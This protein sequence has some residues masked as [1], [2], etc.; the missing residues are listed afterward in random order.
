MSN[1]QERCSDEDSAN[2]HLTSLS[3]PCSKKVKKDQDDTG[4]IIPGTF[5]EPR[6]M[7]QK[8]QV[9][10]ASSFNANT[11]VDGGNSLAQIS[12]NSSLSS[13]YAKSE[14]MTGGGNL[15]TGNGG[16]LN[17]NDDS[18]NDIRSLTTND[19]FEKIGLSRKV[20]N[21][22]KKKKGINY[23]YDWQKEF[24]TKPKL[25]EGEN[26]ILSL[27]TGAGKSLIADLLMLRE[28]L[29]NNKNCIIILPYVAGTQ[30]KTLSLSAFEDLGISVKIYTRFEGKI[31]PAKKRKGQSIYVATIERA[32]TLINS[33]IKENRLQEIGLIV[34]DG[35]HMIGEKGRGASIEKLL[36]KYLMFGSGQIIG[37]STTIGDVSE[38]CKFMKAKHFSSDFRPVKVIERVKIGDNLYNVNDEGDL[39]LHKKLEVSDEIKKVDSDGIVS[40]IKDISPQKQVVIFCPTRDNCEHVCKLVATLLPGSSEILNDQR[41]EIIDYILHD[42]EWK[43]DKNMEIGIRAGIAY[44]HSGLN[45]EEKHYIETGFKNGALY[46]LCATST[47]AAGANLPVRCVIINQPKVRED[48]IEKSQYL[49][50]I[51]RAGRAGYEGEGESITIVGE[52]YEERFRDMLKSPLKPC[53]SQM[54]DDVNLKGLILDLIN[55]KLVEKV[56]ELRNFLSKTLAGIQNNDECLSLMERVSESLKEQNMVEIENGVILKSNY[57]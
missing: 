2:E 18:S 4:N 8:R 36:F 42:N 34:V 44:H 55:L 21:F 6:I 25:L 33:L 43:I 17:F 52:G 37:M 26:Y 10:T 30:E 7:S 39:V 40:L 27:Q 15:N 11:G 41:E 14:K 13:N 31:P 51:G 50:M 46:A 24:L 29:V 56:E 32:D 16:T 48:F 12:S 20:Q 47:L 38:M 28:N 1:G 5:E 19:V 3:S 35:L 9:L 57:R 45:S 53:Q 22:Y 49:Q 23:L 54:L